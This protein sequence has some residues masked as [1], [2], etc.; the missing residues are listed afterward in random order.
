MA[1]HFYYPVNSVSIH[2]YYVV[3]RIWGYGVMTEYVTEAL[4]VYESVAEG[5]IADVV[6][7]DLDVTVNSLS[8]EQLLH[9]PASGLADVDHVVVAG[10]LSGL[11]QVLRLAIDYKFSVGVVPV[12]RQGKI[13]RYLNLPSRQS[14]AIA[15][16][17]RSKSTTM[18]LIFCNQQIMLFRGSIGWIPMLDAQQRDSKLR[19]WWRSVRGSPRPRR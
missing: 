8:L 16:A 7:N 13:A 10:S 6:N 15:F 12:N 17:L 14:E 11:K 1:G 4:F 3:H 19:L 5:L 18:D 2:R 9:D